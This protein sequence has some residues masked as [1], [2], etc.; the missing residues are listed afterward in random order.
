MLQQVKNIIAA[1][2]PELATQQEA[3]NS[4]IDWQA[5][6]VA[7]AMNKDFAIIAGGPGTGK[8]YTVTKLLGGFSDACGCS[9]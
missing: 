9:M 2:F 4:E 8:T 3:G 5:V 1:L 7:N 6:A